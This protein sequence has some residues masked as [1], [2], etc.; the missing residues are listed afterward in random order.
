MDQQRNWT[1]VASAGS[2]ARGYASRASRHAVLDS[3]N[4]Q[5]G[6]FAPRGP[7]YQ[8]CTRGLVV[9]S[10]KNGSPTD[11]ASARRID[12]EG[13]PAVH[14]TRG[15]RGST[16]RLAASSKRWTAVRTKGRG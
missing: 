2:I 15:R 16:A 9:E 7:A 6:S 4:S 11:A 14:S 12:S 8:D 5:Y 10:R 1:G 13:L 3:A